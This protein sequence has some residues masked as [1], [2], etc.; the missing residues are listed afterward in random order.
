MRG[1]RWMGLVIRGDSQRHRLQAN[2]ISS[3]RHPLPLP[4]RMRAPTPAAEG[5]RELW[6]LTHSA[7]PVNSQHPQPMAFSLSNPL[8]LLS[9]AVESQLQ[10]DVFSS[11]RGQSRDLGISVIGQA[12]QQEGEEGRE[13]LGT[14]GEVNAT[15]A[16]ISGAHQALGTVKPFLCT[17]SFTLPTVY[18]SRY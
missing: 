10:E 7:L 15:I 2:L 13:L 11:Q 9:E 5:K 1:S 8:S 18:C 14:V 16:T 3:S 4:S 12:K 17:I 6:L